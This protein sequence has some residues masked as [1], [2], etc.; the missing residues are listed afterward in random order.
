MNYFFVKVVINCII[1]TLCIC[2]C[3]LF[4]N[5]I[6]EYPIITLAT[7]FVVYIVD[8]IFEG[9]DLQNAANVEA[10][11]QRYFS[12][13]K[14]AC[15]KIEQTYIPNFE[16]IISL[17]SNDEKNI[18]KQSD[19]LENLI[20]AI[21]CIV[22]TLDLIIRDTK[23]FKISQKKL[24][25]KVIK[26]IDK[27]TKEQ[28]ENKKNVDLRGLFSYVQDT[29][30]DDVNLICGA[31]NIEIKKQKYNNLKNDWIY[32]NRIINKILNFLATKY[33]IT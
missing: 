18:T 21:S 28:L 20:D 17:M 25:D 31:K 22:S 5:Y 13:V 12:Q 6:K 33:K 1:F 30:S 4:P 29:I 15:L 3:V 2:S 26:F 8:K 11:E 10:F 9:I 14:Q 16:S 7:F 24:N 27:R 32:F 19:I 23:S